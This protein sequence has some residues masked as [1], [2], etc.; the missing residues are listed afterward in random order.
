M[1][2]K[3]LRRLGQHPAKSTVDVRESEAEWLIARGAAERASSAAPRQ[4]QAPEPPVESDQ[5]D[6]DEPDS[7]SM[8]L[9]ELRAQADER[10]LP[11]YGTKAQLA[12]RI[13]NDAADQD[14]Q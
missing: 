6:E 7:Q 5:D 8:T 12:A 9:A 1:R 10:G 3:L 13:A 14:E 4:H 11:T 2:V